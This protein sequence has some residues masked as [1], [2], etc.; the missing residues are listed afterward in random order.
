MIK[1]PRILVIE[2]TPE[3]REDLSLELKD[4]GYE[5]IETHD[6]AAALAA[7]WHD[8][9]DLVICDIQLPDMDGLSVLEA[10]RADETRGIPTPVIV[11]SAFSDISLRR[12]AEAFALASF[13][14]KPVDYARLLI[15]IAECLEEAATTA[16]DE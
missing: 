13:V 10:I 11:V 2:D 6:G 15:L 16:G 7:F 14:L 3:L 5:V 12:K 9:P 4:A 8:R 1:P